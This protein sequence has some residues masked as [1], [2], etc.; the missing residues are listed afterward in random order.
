M[1]FYHIKKQGNTESHQKYLNNIQKYLPQNSSFPN[2]TLLF[3]P[4]KP[5]KVETPEPS[6]PP[7][8]EFLKPPKE[9]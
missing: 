4:V 6:K 1:N 9:E 2:G 5:P 8:I 3:K 7:K